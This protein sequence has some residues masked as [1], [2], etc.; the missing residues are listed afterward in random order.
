MTVAAVRPDYADV[1]ELDSILRDFGVPR[2]LDSRY[3]GSPM[4]F[5]VMQ[6]ALVST[7]RD[8]GM[9]PLYDPFEFHVSHCEYI[10]SPFTAPPHL[11]RTGLERAGTIQYALQVRT[12][13][14]SNLPQCNLLDFCRRNV[15][16]S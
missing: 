11:L 12:V 10:Y 6:R 13:R 3:G 2:I 14:G 15:V 16:Q 9:V 8:I 7:S 1:M 4:R 5:L